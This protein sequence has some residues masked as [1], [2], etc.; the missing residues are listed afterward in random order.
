M[1]RVLFQRPPSAWRAA[2][3]LPAG[4]AF[5]CL[6]FVPA[7]DDDNLSLVLDWRPEI[8]PLLLIGL[9]AALALVGRRVPALLRWLL[10]G[11]VFLI[12]LLQAADALVL[13]IFDRQLDLYFD[14]P[15]VPRLLALFAATA[16]LWRSLAVATAAVL[17]ALAL[18][19]LIA[20][21]IAVCERMLRPPRHAAVALG[22]VL[23]LAAAALIGRIERREPVLALRTGPVVWA[24]TARLW[25]TFRVMH[26]DDGRYA[27]LLAAPQ[28][29]PGALPGLKQ[30]DVYLVFFES[31]GTVALDEP[32]Y[33]AVVAPALADFAATVG[34]AGWHLLSSRI[35]SPTFGGGS[36][37]AHGTIDSGLKLDP[38]LTRLITDSARQTLPRYMRAAGYRSV[39]IMPGIKTPEPEHG[40]WG[41][42]RSL[43]AADLGYDGPPFG[44]FDIPDQYTLRRIDAAEGAPGHAPLFAQIVLVSSHTPFAPVPPYVADWDAAPLYRGIPQ[45]QWDRIY[46]PPD[47]AHLEAPYLASVVYDL[48]I[49]SAWLARLPGD[50][51]VIIL[52]DHQPPSLA[53]GEKQPWTVPI[54]VLSRDPDLLR[55][56]RRL[57]YVEGAL[58]PQRGAFRGMESFLGD[59]IDG[60]ATAPAVAATRPERAEH[61][62]N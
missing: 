44:W 43:Y 37:L 59:F 61:G 46:A 36:W 31:Y 41:F 27:A 55:P 9:L 22:I 5:L 20:V 16:G 33:A 7:R 14:L 57:G 3:V 21:V 51:L 47:W 40:F 29:A 2:L 25:H 62:T 10:A 38:L 26:G 18:I 6:L 13:S 42:E 15:Q 56:F 39:D 17:A 34:Q 23:V 28:P 53:A 45:A 32:R 11:L 4:A 54:H 35:V 49:L 48:R 30:R 60:F 8:E 58:P 19:A 12:A 1:K 24:Q 52:G 50:A